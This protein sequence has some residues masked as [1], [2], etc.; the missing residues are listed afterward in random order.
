LGDWF[1]L[2]PN[3]PGKAQLTPPEVTASAFLYYDAK[4]LSQIAQVLS[5]NEDAAGYRDKA[6]QIRAVYN[7]RFFDSA[8]GQYASGS[9]CA[10]A[11]PLAMGI[12]EKSNRE[13][14]L[15]AL[16]RDIESRDFSTTAGDVGFRFVLRALAD[17]GRSDVVYQMVTQDSKPGYG[18]MLKKGETSLTESWDAN[19]TTSHN[20]FM[21]GQVTEWLYHDLAGIVPDPNGPGFRKFIVKPQPVGDLSWVKASYRSLH[22]EIRSEWRIE[23]GKFSLSVLVPANTSATIHIPTRP[24]IQV[25]PG[26][27]RF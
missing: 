20:H 6:D 11:L 15:S 16:V 3:K 10:N 13:A 9:Q 24:P 4:I 1:D 25:G 5:A 12:V 21:L 22:G 26:Q 17:G 18:Y 27:Y 14:V 23:N 19:L 7:R 8:K 2:G